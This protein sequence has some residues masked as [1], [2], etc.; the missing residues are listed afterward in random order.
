M[1]Y[2]DYYQTLG[3]SRDADEKEIKRAYRRLARQWH[4]D[5]NPGND[6]AEER[7]KDINEA[8]EV[9]A[10]PEKRRKYDQLGADWR[11][12]QQASGRPGG[13]DWSRW[14][15]DP[16]E[17]GQRVH[18]RY[19]TPE[20]I[21]DLFGGG[22]PFSD[23][24]S[25]IFGG[26]GG[27]ATPGGY[28]Y[29][30]RPQR[31][32]DFEQEVEVSLREAYQGTTRTLQKDGRHLEVK[33]PAGSRTGTRIRM[34]GEGGPGDGGGETGDLYLRVKVAPDPQFERR[35]GDLYVTV[36]VDLYTAIL[37]GQVRVPT[38]SGPV[39]LSIPAG[40]QNGRVFRLRGK[41]MPSLRQEDLYGDLYAKVDIQVPTQLTSRQR[42]LFEELR[43]VSQ[44]EGER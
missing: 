32:Q 40:T 44:L 20:D 6:E 7:F 23:F 17:G 30:V 36:P 16:G 41:G 42:E 22:S 38:L 28:D 21:E 18:V 26:M 10:D 5:V 1:E 2:K 19:S 25:Q 39:M 27:G 34:A 43:R 13:F 33:I 11:R 14:T 29:R 3:V 35:D 24:F 8:Y 9:L 31:G 12:W 37:G 15:T 4:P